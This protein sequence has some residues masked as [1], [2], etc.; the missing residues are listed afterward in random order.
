MTRRAFTL[1]ELLVVIS[2]IALLIGILLPALG[3]ARRTAQSAVCKNHERQQLLASAMHSDS[4]EERIVVAVSYDEERPTI[5]PY[6]TDP[7]PYYHDEL[8]PLVGGM[9]V[10]TAAVGSG[11]ENIPDV[12]LCPSREGEQTP[13]ELPP[14]GKAREPTYRV[15]CSSPIRAI[16]MKIPTYATAD[17][18]MYPRVTDIRHPTLT[19]LTYDSVLVSWRDRYFPH[20]GSINVGYADGHV[21][22]VSY[23]DYKEMSPY[24]GEA[25]GN[26]EG[27]LN[28]WRNEFLTNGWPKSWFNEEYDEFPQ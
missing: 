21:M 4:N 14:L 3:A 13:I 18:S 28:E 2:I 1:I 16:S 23:V 26:G 12:F 27:L 25:G 8:A 19:V 22:S 11:R 10:V 15:A 17:K 5:D 6:V 20:R 7:V 9:K 24:G